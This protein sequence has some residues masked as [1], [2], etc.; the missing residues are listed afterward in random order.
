MYALPGLY[1][2]T[3]QTIQYMEPKKVSLEL[4]GKQYLDLV[5]LVFIGSLVAEEVADDEMMAKFIEAQQ[6]LMAA[7]GPGKGNSYIGY[8]PGDEEYFLAEDVEEPLLELLNEYDESRFWE[9]LVMRLTLRDLQKKFSEKELDEMPDEKGA[10][11][12]EAIHSYYIN[13]FDDNDLDNLKVIS[14]KKV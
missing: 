9:N 14:M 3:N 13:E 10:K 1:G 2:N 5:R 4:T 8:D 12:M 7:S 6:V 11:E